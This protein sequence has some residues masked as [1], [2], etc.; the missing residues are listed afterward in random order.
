MGSYLGN[1]ISIGDQLRVRQYQVRSCLVMYAAM[2]W[3]LRSFFEAEGLKGFSIL[4]QAKPTTVQRHQWRLSALQLSARLQLQRLI[5][6]PNVGA[7]ASLASA[8]TVFLSR[9]SVPWLNESRDWHFVTNGEVLFVHYISNYRV[10]CRTVELQL[11]LS[12]K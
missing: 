8:A 12:Q 2:L 7:A 3:K 1:L 10:N 6:R 4:S 11:T 9:T 5:A